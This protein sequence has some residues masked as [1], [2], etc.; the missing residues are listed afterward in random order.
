MGNI[1]NPKDNNKMMDYYHYAYAIMESLGE[2]VYK[3]VEDRRKLISMHFSGYGFDMNYD[4]N[5]SS[6]TINYNGLVKYTFE[7]YTP[8]EWENILELVYLGIDR[9]IEEREKK[10]KERI[11]KEYLL[12]EVS[13]LNPS[14]MSLKDYNLEIFND[15]HIITVNNKQIKIKMISLYHNGIKVLSGY[16]DELGDANIITY[17]PG[18]WESYLGTCRKLQ[19][20]HLDNNVHQNNLKRTK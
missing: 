1:I 19:Q 9:I 12:L 8:G 4:E 16:Y 17:V 14:E 11:L 18:K 20:M 2:K 6:I 10:E 13:W 15:E 3:T 7:G 5:N